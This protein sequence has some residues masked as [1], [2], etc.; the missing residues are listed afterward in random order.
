[1]APRYEDLAL[2]QNGMA[3]REVGCTVKVS[4]VGLGYVGSVAAA[5]LAASGHEVLGIDIDREKVETYQRGQTPFYEPGLG[6]LIGYGVERGNLRFVQAGEVSEDLGE[7]IVIATGTPTGRFG[8]ADLSQVTAAVRWITEVQPSGGV[9]VM[10]STVPPKTGARILDT[11]LKGTHFEYVSNPEFLREG[12]AVKDWSFPDRIVVGAESDRSIQTVKDL[13]SGIDAPLVITDITSAEMVKYA[14]NAFLAT[15]ISFIN[16]IAMLCDKVDANIDDV[17]RGISLDPRIGPS[18]LKAGVG[19]GGSCFPKDTRALDGLGLNSGHNLELL[20]AVIAINN[21][22]RFLPFYA[23]RQRFGSVSRLCVG[24]LGLS[25]KPDTDDIR[26]APA[27]D[28]VRLLVEEGASVKA[29]DP[30][31][32]GAAA[33]ALPEAVSLVEDPLSCAEETNALVLMTEWPAI[34]NADWRTIASLTHSPCFL[35]DGRNALDPEQMQ[36]YGFE[37]QGV[38]RGSMRSIRHESVV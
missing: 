26:E 33:K 35:F 20:R 15:K 34:I 28:L 29:Y 6:E 14:A 17:A 7:A 36:A 10:K 13:Y 9:I 31:A 16:E 30:R 8:A 37:Y 22:Q 21:R 3:R 19:Y 5:G 32:L 11:I 1:M 4:I 25:F 27:I 24:V 18:F 2:S 12:Q 38:G 23:L